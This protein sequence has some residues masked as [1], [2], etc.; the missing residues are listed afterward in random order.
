MGASLVGGADTPL[1]KEVAAYALSGQ[2]LTSGTGTWRACL[3]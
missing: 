1:V 2:R 3:Y